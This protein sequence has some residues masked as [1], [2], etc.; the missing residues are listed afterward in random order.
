MIREKDQNIIQLFQN[1]KIT[2]LTSLKS[3][4]TA[5]TNKGF[6][7]IIDKKMKFYNWKNYFYIWD[8]SNC[9]HRVKRKDI[10]GNKINL[11]KIRVTS[12]SRK[13]L[14]L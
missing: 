1:L 11:P 2:L 4:S 10:K 3:K 9:K 7:E 8:L 13:S 6:K 5:L 14:H 12:T